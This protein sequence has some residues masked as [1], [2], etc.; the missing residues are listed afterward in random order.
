ML[1]TVLQVEVKIGELSRKKKLHKSYDVYPTWGHAAN[2][3]LHKSYVLTSVRGFFA[4]GHFAVGQFTV[5]KNVNFG[6]VKLGQIR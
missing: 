6:K 2:H 5:R 1:Y 4:V 3:K